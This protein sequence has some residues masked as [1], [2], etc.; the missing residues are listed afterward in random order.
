MSI[1]IIKHGANAKIF[2]TFICMDC[3]C[4]FKTDTDYHTERTGFS[5]APKFASTCP[6][7]GGYSIEK[8]HDISKKGE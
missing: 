3:G 1:E 2:R 7:C 6:E 5:T 8:I 4:E